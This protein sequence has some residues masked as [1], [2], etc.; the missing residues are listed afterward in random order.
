[1]SRTLHRFVLRI[2]PSLWAKFARIA[3]KN[4][5]S[6]NAELLVLIEKCV[7]EAEENEK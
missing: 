2:K 3:E 4:H 1:M 5:R 6:L 7:A